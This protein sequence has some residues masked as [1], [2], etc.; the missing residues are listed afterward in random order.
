ML[1]ICV[2]SLSSRTNFRWHVHCRRAVCG[3]VKPQRV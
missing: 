3:A 2:S 1:P